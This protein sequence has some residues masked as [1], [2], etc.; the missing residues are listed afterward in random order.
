MGD[1]KQPP[2][3]AAEANRTREKDNPWVRLSRSV[4]YENDWI[5][6]YHDE[7][8]RPD[9]QPGI[10]GVVHYRSR[11]VGVV[12][13]DRRDRVLL[14]GQ[15]RYT[16]GCYSW[17]IPAGGA[18]EGEEPLAAARRELREETGYSPASMQL[19][20]RAHMSDS[21]SDEEGYCYLASDLAEGECCPEGTERLKVRW[22]PFDEALRMISRGDIT[23]ALTIL[24][25]Q[26]AALQRKE[27][28]PGRSP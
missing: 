8:L 2:V 21:I 25:L 14:V 11:S 18:D 17:E 22:L 19:L 27:C 6:V 4:A 28:G 24:G 10:Y 3:G 7:V 13:I 26:Q 20:V 23:D 9:A 15:Y 1:A 16:L 12:A 5:V